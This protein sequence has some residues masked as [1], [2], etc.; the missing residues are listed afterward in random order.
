MNMIL[1]NDY[2]LDLRTPGNSPALANSRK[3][4]RHNFT[5]PMKKRVRP[6][7]IQR[8]TIRLENFGFFSERAI[9][10]FFGI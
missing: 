2:Q 7:F 10:D 6:Q 5:F 8:R 1:M 4:I 9:V 3:Q